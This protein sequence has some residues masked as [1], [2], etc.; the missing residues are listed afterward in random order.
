[1][2]GISSSLKKV[3]WYNHAR[4]NDMRQAGADNRGSLLPGTV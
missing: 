1:M 3:L 4:S 2:L